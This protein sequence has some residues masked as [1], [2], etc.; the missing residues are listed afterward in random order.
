MPRPLFA[1][2]CIVPLLG[3][4]PPDHI[5]VDPASPHLTRRGDTI[6]LHGRV[7]DRAGK[8]HVRERAFWISSNPAVA[9]VSELGDLT[10]VSSGRAIITARA[11]SL[12]AEVPAQVELVESLRVEPAQVQ[13]S[14]ESEPLKLAVSA[15]GHDG[16]PVLDRAVSFKSAD[17][18]IVRVDPE[19]RLWALTPGD[20][21][22]RASVDDKEARI[23]VHVEGRAAGA[24]K[25]RGARHEAR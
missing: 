23:A 22:V 17:P 9:T 25:A 18:E 13:L 21:V 1:A 19:G 12:R 3:C 2:L 24:K 15:I 16:H 5:D 11:G 20:A 4:L 10:A 7:M 14:P 8:Q 6:R